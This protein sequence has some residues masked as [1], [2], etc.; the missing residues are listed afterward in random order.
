MKPC[1]EECQEHALNI[2]INVLQSVVVSRGAILSLS[3]IPVAASGSHHPLEAYNYGR[4]A[5]FG[6]VEPSAQ[7]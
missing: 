3:Y 5:L 2:S 6:L 1:N 7:R 4:L